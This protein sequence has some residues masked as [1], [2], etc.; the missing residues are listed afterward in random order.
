MKCLADLSPGESAWITNHHPQSESGLRLLEMGL[1]DG[2]RVRLTKIAP[3]GDPI[4]IEIMNYR[5][6]LRKESAK[7]IQVSMS[8][9]SLANKR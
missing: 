8:E 1:V 4:E 9:P 3:L 2:E 6:C 5:L 7:N